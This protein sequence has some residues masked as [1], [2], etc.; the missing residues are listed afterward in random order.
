[1]SQKPETDISQPFIDATLSILT[2]MAGMSAS[3]GKPF[4]KNSRMASGSVSAI[5]GV[6]GDMRGTISVSFSQSCAHALVRGMLGVDIEDSIED[7]QDAVG[8][9]ANMVSGQARAGLKNMGITLQGSTP[10]VI[11]GENH[12]I[13][14]I[15]ASPA[16]AIPFETA[17]GAFTVEFCL[18]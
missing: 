17:S 2:A 12:I 10:T 1:M 7:I 11:I 8:E 9:M 16:N 14:H 5:V 15:S 4:V 13:R 18:E 3:V 6:T